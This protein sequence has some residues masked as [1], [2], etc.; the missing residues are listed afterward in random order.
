M[1]ITAFFLGASTNAPISFLT[2][3][4]KLQRLFAV[5]ALAVPVANPGLAERDSDC[6]DGELVGLRK[7]RN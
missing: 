4:K 2:M 7:H 3:W 1:Y 6:I 5:A